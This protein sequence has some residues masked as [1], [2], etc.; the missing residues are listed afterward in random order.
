MP[1][2]SYEHVRVY[3]LTSS[4][5]APGTHG[6]MVKIFEPVEKTRRPR[7]SAGAINVTLTT[8]LFAS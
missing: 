3:A 4:R 2:R 1:L 7:P 5:A 8:S 6:R